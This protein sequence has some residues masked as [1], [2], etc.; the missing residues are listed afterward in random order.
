MMS[1]LIME[2]SLTTTDIVGDNSYHVVTADGT[3]TPITGTTVLDGFTITAGQ[4]NGDQLRSIGEVAITVMAL[5]LGVNAVPLYRIADFSG[6]YAEYGGAMYNLG[7]DNGTSKPNLRDVTFSGNSAGSNGGAMFNNGN[8]GD[9][10]P[11]LE[12]VTFSGNSADTHG[13]A[14]YNYGQNG[15]SSPSMRGVTFFDNHA[16]YGGALANHGSLGASDPSLKDVIFSGNSADED[17][18]AMFN[19]CRKRHQQSQP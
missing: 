6:N 17:G 13:G 14:I 18:G 7:N 8:N 5:G 15:I 4:A 12:D 2:L 1:L 16:A 19:R 9:S 10:S 11:S 3:S